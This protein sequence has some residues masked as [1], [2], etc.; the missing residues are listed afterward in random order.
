[1]VIRGWMGI[2]AEWTVTSY[3]AFAIQLM[4]GFGLA[5]ELP[6]VVVILGR[7]GIVSAAQLREKRRH[8]LVFLLILAMVLTPPDVVTQ[9]LMAVPLA[10]LYEVC[11]LLVWA[12]EKKAG[13]GDDLTTG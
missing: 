2:E 9:L 7:M 8:V 5:F 10:I 4:I 3:V 1:M 11:I 12:S 6:V 13:L